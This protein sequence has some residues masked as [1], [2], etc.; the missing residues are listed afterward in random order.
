MPGDEYALMLDSE[1]PWLD[2]LAET[3]R[4]AKEAGEAARRMENQL[5]QLIGSDKG[6]ETETKRVTWVRSMRNGKLTNG[7]IRITEKKG[8]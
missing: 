7:G 1:V 8:A 2:E 5:R 4:A 6:I 3:K